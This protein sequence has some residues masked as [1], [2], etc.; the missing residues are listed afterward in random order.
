MPCSRSSS[1]AAWVIALHAE[2]AGSPEAAPGGGAAR[3]AAGCLDHRC[4]RALLEQERA[5]RRE[6]GE[7]GAGRGGG[8]GIERLGR[9]AC[10]RAAAERAAAVAAVGCRGVEDE[11]DRAVRRGRL[12][13][14][15]AHARLVGHVA[16]HGERAG[17]GDAGERLLRPGDAGHGPALGDEQ[18]D[19]RR[20]RGCALRR[21]RRC[22]REGRSRSS[23]RS[24]PDR[25]ALRRPPVPRSDSGEWDGDRHVRSP[26]SRWLHRAPLWN[27]VTLSARRESPS[28]RPPELRNARPFGTG[29]FVAVA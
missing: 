17:G 18:L 26:A 19:R 14:H 29:R 20:G 5:G 1:A 16:A 23:P 10:D 11:I 24:I 2:R 13:E 4:G 12:L 21:R 27:V 3:R 9:G 15:R 28:G 6:E 22:G 7:G 25:F 8:P